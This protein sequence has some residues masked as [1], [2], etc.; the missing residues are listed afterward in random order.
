MSSTFK[1]RILLI[2]VSLLL[3]PFMLIT[4]VF[5]LMRFGM[6]A[7]PVKE[8][9]QTEIFLPVDKNSKKI[10]DPVRIGFHGSSFQYLARNYY[11]RSEISDFLKKVNSMEK[12]KA[13]S[14]DLLKVTFPPGAPEQADTTYIDHYGSL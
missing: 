9:V 3:I 13:A 12:V 5:P 10:L 7:E 11:Y 14:I 8:E 6:F 2:T 1:N 4:D